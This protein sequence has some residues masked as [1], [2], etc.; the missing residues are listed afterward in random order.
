MGG[1]LTPAFAF[2]R[3]TWLDRIQAAAL[4]EKNIHLKNYD[5]MKTDP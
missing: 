2:H 3:T 1:V 5:N 4:A